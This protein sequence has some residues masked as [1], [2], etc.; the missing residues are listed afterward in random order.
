MPVSTGM[1]D[2]REPLSVFAYEMKRPHPTLT[3]QSQ[4]R[5]R[6]CRPVSLTIVLCELCVA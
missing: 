2:V 3:I 4:V 1:R 6:V 5:P